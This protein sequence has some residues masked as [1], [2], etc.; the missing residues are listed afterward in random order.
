MRIETVYKATSLDDAL[1]IK[2]SSNKNVILG[3]ALWLRRSKRTVDTAIDLSDLALNFIDVTEDKIVIGAY[4]SLKTIQDHP[5]LHVLYQ[6]ILPEAINHIMGVQ[7]R[8]MAT[9]GGSIIGRYGFSDIITPLLC[10]DVILHFHEGE[11]ITL[12]D[13]IKTKGPV[14]DILTH[15][16]I[17]KEKGTGY[18]KKCAP[19]PLSFSVLNIAITKTNTS[20]K[21]AIGSRPSIAMLAEKT[22][23]YLSD[24]KKIDETII[25]HAQTH[26]LK[27]V[28]LASNNSASERY[29]KTLAS[30]YLERGLKA[31]N[32]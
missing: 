6:G 13:F 18:F 24:Q 25:Q 23:A 10:M 30:V 5:D 29:R 9:L 8:H 27:E 16:E 7:L 19:S 14:D 15:V 28:M 31:V 32:K 11:A 26:L 17:M 3:G 12:D 4:T 1:A 20:Y 21:I 22:S 2:R